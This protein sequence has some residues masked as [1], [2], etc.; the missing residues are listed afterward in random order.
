M[1]LQK[2]KSTKEPI[3]TST[4]TNVD[5]TT[6][7]Y[8]FNHLINLSMCVKRFFDRNPDIAGNRQTSH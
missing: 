3:S 4:N 6:A 5:S 2:S 1:L 8:P 7:N